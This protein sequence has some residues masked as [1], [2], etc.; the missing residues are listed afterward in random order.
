MKY[1]IRSIKYFIYISCIITL[2]LAVLVLL[3]MVSPDVNVMF[4]NGWKSVMQIAIM[5]LAVSAIYPRFGYTKRNIHA[6]GEY[7]ELRSTVIE[8]MEAHGY[9]LESEEGQD[10]CFRLKSPVSRLFKSFEDRITLSKELPGFCMEGI[11]KDVTKLS[12]GL[13][14]KFTIPGE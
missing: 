5:F 8:F 2:I 6:R 10:M 9:I 14:Q 7:S 4:R 1:I 13:E 12:Y 11:T 3:K